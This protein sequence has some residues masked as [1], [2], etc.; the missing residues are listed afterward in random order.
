MAFL[1]GSIRDIDK[2][3]VRRQL[4]VLSNQAVFDKLN[5]KTHLIIC[6]YL[7]RCMFGPKYPRQNPK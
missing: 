3:L 1:S 6:P 7:S 5:V 2:N 4:R